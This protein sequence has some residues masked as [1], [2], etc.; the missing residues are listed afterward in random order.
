[1]VLLESLSLELGSKMPPF[2]LQDPFLNKHHSTDLMGDNG[3]AIFFTCNHCPYA[4]AIW[5]RSLSFAK[6]AQNIGINTVAINPNINPAYPDDSPEAMKQKI[7]SDNIIF[8]YLVDEK[9]D[10]AQLYKAQCTP[11]IYLLKSDMSLFYHGRLDDN[12]QD[13]DA[14]SKEELWNAAECLST[15]KAAPQPQ[16]PSMGCSIKW[17]N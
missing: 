10:I 12:W 9:Q 16:F 14:V 2:S 17:V 5:D 3:L 13:P 15:D 11:D 1:M 6:K 4:I 7:T 8:P